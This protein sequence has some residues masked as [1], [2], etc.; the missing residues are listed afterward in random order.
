[1]ANSPQLPVTVDI[2]KQNL[3]DAVEAMSPSEY[4]R[5]HPYQSVAAAFALGMVLAENDR[6]RTLLIGSEILKY[7]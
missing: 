7:L 2:A 6:A 4:V 5:K 1:M 3:R